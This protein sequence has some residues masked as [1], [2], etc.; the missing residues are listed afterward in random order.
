[1]PSNKTLSTLCYFSIFFSP[2]LLPIIIL[3]VTDDTEV[4]FHA[5]R[6]L[7][8][9]ILPVALLIVGFVIFSM[10]MFSAENRMLEMVTGRFNIWSV[11][12]I[13]FILLYGL[14]TAI[15]FL[16]NIIQ[17]VKLLK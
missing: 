11:S 17:G 10:S 6:S 3:L 14:V 15:I 9:H 12:P 13:I 7:I 8:S 5:K 2:L 16:W 1:M 4:K